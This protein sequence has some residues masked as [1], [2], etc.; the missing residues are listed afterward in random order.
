MLTNSGADTY[1][2]SMYTIIPRTR[3][4]KLALGYLPALTVANTEQSVITVDHNWSFN[5]SVTVWDVSNN[6]E[7]LLGVL[8]T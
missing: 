7:Y 6:H 1:L 5:T 2:S 3:K 4:S 8:P